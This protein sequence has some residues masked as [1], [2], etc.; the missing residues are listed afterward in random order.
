MLRSFIAQGQ[1]LMAG[2]AAMDVAAKLSGV[3]DAMQPLT[4]IQF[5]TVSGEP[6]AEPL[7]A[8]ASLDEVLMIAQDGLLKDVKAPITLKAQAE[9]LSDKVTTWMDACKTY[10]L[11]QDGRKEYQDVSTRT[12]ITVSEAILLRCFIEFRDKPMKLKRQLAAEHSDCLEKGYWQ[13]VNAILRG[14]VEKAIGWKRSIS[15]GANA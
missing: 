8:D 9:T 13:D 6:W 5:G 10:Q 7:S 15:S 1:T 14:E 2:Q 3:A 12:L 11:P 4:N